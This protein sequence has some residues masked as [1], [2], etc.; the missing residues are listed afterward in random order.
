MTDTAEIPDDATIA[1][2][3]AGE[4]E[5]PAPAPKPSRS[6]AVLNYVKPEEAK[7]DL[8]YSLS[9]LSGAMME[10]AALHLDY[11]ERAAKAARQVNDL[12][13]KLEAAESIVYREI[14]DSY[15]KSG[16]KITEALLEKEVA[17]HQTIR[18]IKLAINEAKQ[19]EAIA[20]GAVEAFGQRKDMLVQLGAKDRVELE[21]ELRMNAVS[22]R[23]QSIKDT[24]AAMLER[25]RAMLGGAPS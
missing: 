19:I 7:A 6:I 25:R 2:L 17:A 11:A 20:K 24:G 14:R 4:A 3:E 12:K 5:K 18:K 16:T 9:D 13:V 22:A 10:Q 21:G 15:A 23:E 8:A 1:A